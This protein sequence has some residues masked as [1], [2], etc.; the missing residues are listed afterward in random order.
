MRL[1]P[2][3]PFVPRRSYLAAAFG[4]AEP[5]PEVP[6]SNPGKDKGTAAEP[7][8]AK[9]VLRGP[10]DLPSATQGVSAD[11]DRGV[12]DEMVAAAQSL[13]EGLS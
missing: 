8:A 3:G 10:D 5:K 7:T 12:V 6:E 2:A 1:A 11:Y 9:W 4:S 13:V